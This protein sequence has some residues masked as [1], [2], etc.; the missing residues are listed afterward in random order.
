LTEEEEKTFSPQKIELG[1]L[2]VEKGC[3][4]IGKTIIQSNIRDEAQC[5]VMAVIRP[6]ASAVMNPNPDLTFAEGD[7]IILA[8][9]KDNI[10]RLKESNGYGQTARTDNP[11]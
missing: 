7:I 4:L 10:K 2:I 9:E 11:Q 1:N 8:G 5:V 6:D 3:P